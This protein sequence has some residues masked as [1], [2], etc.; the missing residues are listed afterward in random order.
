[1]DICLE[2]LLKKKF[3]GKGFDKWTHVPNKIIVGMST[4]ESTC[5]AVSARWMH[6][7]WTCA[8]MFKSWTGYMPST[9]RSGATEILKAANGNI[10]EIANVPTNGF[11][12]IYKESQSHSKTGIGMLL[13]SGK[14][15]TPFK[16][17]YRD[18]KDPIVEVK[19]PRGWTFFMSVA[20]VLNLR[21]AYSKPLVGLDLPGP[22][23]YVFTKYGFTVDFPDGKLAKDAMHDEDII[24]TKQAVAQLRKDFKPEVGTIYVRNGIRYMSLGCAPKLNMSRKNVEA[25]LDQRLVNSM[26]AVLTE[27]LERKNCNFHCGYLL[28][29]LMTNAIED[30]SKSTCNSPR[31]PWQDEEYIKAIAAMRE[32]LDTKSLCTY[33]KLGHSNMEYY[34]PQPSKEDKDKS[35]MIVFGE[36]ADLVNNTDSVDYMH[37]SV[38]RGSFLDYDLSN[39]ALTQMPLKDASDMSMM[40][41]TDNNKLI[42]EEVGS[43]PRK[44]KYVNV[45]EK[46]VLQAI[47]KRVTWFKKVIDLFD[48]VFPTKAPN[49]SI[50]D[51]AA[52]MDKK[53]DGNVSL[54]QMLMPW[55]IKRLLK[56]GCF[57][58]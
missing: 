17:G 9:S 1:M 19:D 35:D 32:Q 13:P 23:V 53:L 39:T 54:L 36:E 25:V 45:D 44:Y 3:A 16:Q 47:D 50:E 8:S 20:Q 2:E 52:E 33:A 29:E 24:N 56:H 40:P 11:K 41:T 30:M 6:D 26:E 31:F 10:Q 58:K 42:I 37:I 15:A 14:T 49:N 22:L 38:Y 12:L 48:E 7:V 28:K 5:A 55:K 21:A 27:V 43:Y 51:W 18:Y 4:H 57:L 34:K 46:L